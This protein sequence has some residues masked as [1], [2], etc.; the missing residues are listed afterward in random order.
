MTNSKW[1]RRALLGSVAL[2]VTV[3]GAQADELSTLMT[4]PE[5]FQNKANWPEAAPIAMPVGDSMITFS[6]GQGSLVDWQVDRD[7]PSDSGFT[8]A[9]TPTADVPAPVSELSVSGYVKGDMIYDFD[10]DNLG[11]DF[12]HGTKIDE[13]AQKSSGVS[14]N[15]VQTRFRIKSKMDTAI[16][17]VRTL[18][19]GDF[20]NDDGHFRAR[21]AWGEWDMTP[22]LT[23]GAGQTYLTGCDTVAGLTLI[24]N[25]GSA[26]GCGQ[27]TR[28][29]TVRLAYKSG[30][31]TFRIAVQEPFASGGDDTYGD[32]KVER[33]P[34]LPAVASSVRYDAPGGHQLFLGATVS[35]VDFDNG[36]DASGDDISFEGGTAWEFQA[37]A[38]VNLGDIATLTGHF[39]YNKGG[40]HLNGGK[41]QYSFNEVTS[42][43]NKVTTVTGIEANLL[44]SWGF[45]AGLSFDVSDS[46]TLNVQYGY[47]NP[48]GTESETE[49]G[50]K[51][52]ET[53]HAN[54]LW[55]PV[56]QMRLGVEAVYG[57]KKT[58]EGNNESAL[59]G[60]FGAWFFF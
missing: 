53:L 25:G 39:D 36:V 9:I 49:E 45:L 54:I 38:D 30:P 23:L 12:G 47:A 46:T 55:R 22:N 17:Q 4:Q 8:I 44:E 15:A 21:H 24:D 2:G 5:Y 48:V 58:L 20:W 14:F 16:G 43:E 6:S 51:S 32:Y 19:E 59:R 35:P 40:K 31:T 18:V 27:G 29:G 11:K 60:Q 37:G 41:E 33:S 13:G 34:D 10:Q 26:G 3:T 56:D 28:K 42:T 50:H 1:L 7:I 52:V 57:S